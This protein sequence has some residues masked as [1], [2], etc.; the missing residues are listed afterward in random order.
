MHWQW[1]WHGGMSVI[2]LTF[3]SSR[4]EWWLIYPSHE[5]GGNIIGG[6]RLECLD[7]NQWNGIIHCT[8]IKWFP[9]VWCHSSCAFPAIIMSHSPL[10][11]L[12]WYQWI[13]FLL[14][15]C[16]LVYFCYIKCR[17]CR[18]QY[19][20]LSRL[21]SRQEC[22][23]KKISLNIHYWSKVLE[24]LLIQGFFFIFNI[25]ILWNNSEDITTMK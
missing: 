5:V 9:G 4:T 8:S 15:L 13:L 24:H 18:M 16:W 12:L 10:S 2:V 20:T 7:R 1:D 21:Y 17:H 14:F 25:S 22:G 23:E 6:K 11:S 19:C 3:N